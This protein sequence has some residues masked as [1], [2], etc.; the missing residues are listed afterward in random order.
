M[1]YVS[2]FTISYKKYNENNGNNENIYYFTTKRCFN[3]LSITTNTY[4]SI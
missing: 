2:D 4:I 3:G 1:E